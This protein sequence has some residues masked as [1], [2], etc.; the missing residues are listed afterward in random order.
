MLH[1]FNL[2]ELCLEPHQ[3]CMLRERRK[4]IRENMSLWRQRPLDALFTI[5][6]VRNLLSWVLQTTPGCQRQPQH[7]YLLF[8]LTCAPL[9][10]LLGILGRLHVISFHFGYPN[11]GSGVLYNLVVNTSPW[12]HALRF[13]ILEHIEEDKVIGE[14]VAAKWCQYQMTPFSHAV[15][16]NKGFEPPSHSALSMQGDCSQ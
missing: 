12:M 3:C 16:D 5:S 11:Q 15:H 1:V 14:I 10:G 9:F 6:R 2:F 8:Q 4:A 13:Q 7:P